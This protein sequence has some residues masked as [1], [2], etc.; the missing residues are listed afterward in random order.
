MPSGL[1]AYVEVFPPGLKKVVDPAA[2]FG[3][4]ANLSYRELSSF[5]R[6]PLNRCG[7]RWHITEG[8]WNI[9][10]FKRW[11]DGKE[12]EA[13]LCPNLWLGASLAATE[14]VKYITGRWRRTSVPGM[15]HL[16]TA[17]NK[18]KVEKYRRRSFYFE[19][20]IYWTF[21]IRWLGIGKKYHRYT[22]RRLMRE[23]DG[24]E[25]QEQ[26]GKKARLPVMWHWI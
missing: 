10:W 5:L 1:T 26:A 8:K 9:G 16:L 14:A 20:F 21:G 17:D 2:M 3:S 18:I 4:P 22:A 7:R 25:K 13:Q 23:L 19:K 6:S 12:M 15:W 24:M 11:R